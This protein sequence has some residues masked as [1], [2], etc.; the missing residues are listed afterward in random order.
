MKIFWK[1]GEVELDPSKGFVDRCLSQFWWGFQNPNARKERG[2]APWTLKIMTRRNLVVWALLMAF[3]LYYFT[4]Q[5][6]SNQEPYYGE[7]PLFTILPTVWL[8]T[9]R[10]AILDN[11]L[12]YSWVVVFITVGSFYYLLAITSERNFWRYGIAFWCTWI[13]QY[14]LQLIVNL[15]SPMRNPD[16]DLVFIRGEVFPWSEN[17]VGLKYGAFPSGHIGVTLLVF[18]IARDRG[19]TWVQKMALACL[20]IMFWAILYLG[21]HYLIDAIASAILYPSIYLIITRYVFPVQ[22]EKNKIKEKGE[23]GEK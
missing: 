20:G 16:H 18:M 11:F 9:Y 1:K 17:I 14:T 21:E 8:Q 12:A 7:G 15:A 10:H 13:T 3:G 23:A 6:H 4:F 22:D 19:A 2:E 5:F